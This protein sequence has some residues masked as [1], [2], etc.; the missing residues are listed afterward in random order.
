[1]LKAHAWQAPANDLYAAEEKTM[2]ARVMLIDDEPATLRILV[3]TVLQAG[4]EAHGFADAQS[5]MQALPTASWQVVVCDHILPDGLGTDVCRQISLLS[6]STYRILL[7]GHVDARQLERSVQNADIHRFVAKPWNNQILARYIREGS[8][9]SLLL[10]TVHRLKGTVKN[11][12][13]ALVADKNWIIRLANQRF[14]QLI[15]MDESHL[16]G[17]NLFAPKLSASPLS[18]EPEITRLIE[19]NQTWLGDFTLIGQHGSVLLTRMAITAIN[20][21][22]RICCC[23]PAATEASANLKEMTPLTPHEQ[24]Q[25]A[26][27]FADMLLANGYNQQAILV[28]RFPA[29]QVSDPSS[30]QSCVTRLRQAVQADIAIQSMEPHTFI[31]YE[32][33]HQQHA[34]WENVES[35]IN[36]AFQTPIAL[37][38]QAHQITP[39]TQLV[40]VTDDRT[41]LAQALADEHESIGHAQTLK[42]PAALEPDSLT[43]PQPR[44]HSQADCLALPIFQNSNTL[45]AL[46]IPNEQLQSTSTCLQWYQRMLSQWKTSFDGP[47]QVVMNAS[48][49]TP[50]DVQFFLTQLPANTFQ[51]H[52]WLMI[53]SQHATDVP[54]YRHMNVRVIVRMP[55]TS[56]PDISY[57]TGLQTLKCPQDR[58]DGI[59]LP[60]SLFS[61]LKND[62]RQGCQKLQKLQ[63]SGM[64]IWACHADSTDALAAAHQCGVDWL[65]GDALSAPLTAPQLSWFAQ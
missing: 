33:G 40:Y 14:C 21:E 19:A 55:H 63:Q 49:L 26:L 22:H 42:A 12:L 65:S 17:R 51:Q 56:S 58:P 28:V 36:T 59:C 6:P 46:I 39:K 11:E 10:N 41:N 23:L 31:L 38:N 20:E 9:Q 62:I 2:T 44:A 35:S 54:A 8:R 4:M 13:P 7:S 27:Q 37:Y 48:H 29:E 45:A 61:Y 18:V 50:A 25:S 24:P 60:P 64:L 30:N 15:G 57:L 52:L 3:H 5:A 16:F 34:P 53:D 1:M 32:P 43:T 47:M